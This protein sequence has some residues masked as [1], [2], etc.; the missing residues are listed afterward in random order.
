VSEKMKV[1]LDVGPIFHPKK[2]G[3]PY[4]ATNLVKALQAEHPRAPYQLLL[5]NS[6]QPYSELSE[7][8]AFLKGLLPY[9]EVRFLSWIET[10]LDYLLSL[11][12]TPTVNDASSPKSPLARAAVTPVVMAVKGWNVPVY[13]VRQ[14]MRILLRRRFFRRLE[15]RSGGFHVLHVLSLLQTAQDF[16][17]IPKDVKRC[18]TIYDLATRV[19]PE[20]FTPGIVRLMDETLAYA[21]TCDAVITIS[22][23]S[24]KDLVDL[25]HLPPE[26]VHVIYPGVESIF[27]P[28]PPATFKPVLERYGIEGPYILT[29]GMLDPRKNLPLLVQAFSLLVSERGLKGLRLIITGPKGWDLEKAWPDPPQHLKERIVLTGHVPRQDLPAL[30]NGAAVFCYP[31]LYEGFGLPILEALAC[32]TPVV[33]ANTSSMPEVTGDGG[34][35]V[36]PTDAIAMAEAIRRILEDSALREDLSRKA[37]KQAENFSWQQAAQAH[38]RLYGSLV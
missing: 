35:M 21:K 12:W 38:W 11:E 13:R 33:T 3:I 32:G 34:I 31:S 20:W 14:N 22:H 16:S 1:A 27:H 17:R 36:S 4:Y 18:I 19:N 24:K 2:T 26:R 10:P 30:Y 28:L 15:R 6:Y 29:V 9:P 5:L 8:S 23:N 25:F 7:Y 37:L